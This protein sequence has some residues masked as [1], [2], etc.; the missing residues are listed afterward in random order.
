MV[1]ALG[2]WIVNR[3]LE[4]ELPEIALRYANACDRRQAVRVSAA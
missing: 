2:L 1:L 3:L 4:V